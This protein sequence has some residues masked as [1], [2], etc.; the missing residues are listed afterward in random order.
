MPSTVG[1][2][3][4]LGNIFIAISK[5]Q[6]VF[7]L[8]FENNVKIITLLGNRNHLGASTIVVTAIAFPMHWFVIR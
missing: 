5:G 8:I 2:F 1:L 7:G 4:L 6:V 3:L